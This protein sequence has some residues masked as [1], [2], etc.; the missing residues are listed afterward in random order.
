MDDLI[1][2]QLWGRGIRRTDKRSLGARC[3][4][5]GDDLNYES[6]DGNPCKAEMPW[7]GRCM[8]T[9][10]TSKG[11]AFRTTTT[12]RLNQT[13]FENPAVSVRSQIE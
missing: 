12:V 13:S 9:S 6:I 1:F 7:H 2:L 10:F 5:R 8:R 11:L 4:G 3:N